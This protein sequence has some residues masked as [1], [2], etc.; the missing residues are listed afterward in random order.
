[1]RHFAEINGERA[2]PRKGFRGQCGVCQ[3][4]MIAKCGD[5]VR[6][7][8]AHKSR[9]YCDPW[10]ESESDWHREWKNHF[11]NE[12]HE[13]INFEEGT[14]EKHI[15]DVETPSGLV[16]E[17]QRSPIDGEEKLSRERFYGRMIWVVDGDRGSTDPGYFLMGRARCPVDNDPLVYGVGWMGQGRIWEKWANSS[18]PV[19]IDFGD[20][21]VWRFWQF[22][23]EHRIAYV[24]PIPKQMF[25][26]SCLL[27]NPVPSTKKDVEDVRAFC[28]ER[29]RASGSSTATDQAV[30]YC[31]WEDDCWLLRD[32]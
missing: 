31:V 30:R 9:T 18:K 20:D 2:E 13:I 23:P 24:T 6:W 5:F 29:W 17:F 28:N 1:M 22:I 8:W 7:H 19:Y 25:I 26:E 10:W 27:S 4:E 14:E 21:N 16:I 32:Q 3:V 12:W 15:A 11:P